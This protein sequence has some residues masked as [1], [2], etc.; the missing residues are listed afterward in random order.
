VFIYKPVTCRLAH[1][2]VTQFGSGTTFY[3]GVETTSSRDLFR[4]RFTRIFYLFVRFYGADYF[5]HLFHIYIDIEKD[6]EAANGQSNL[7]MSLIWLVQQVKE[8]HS[9]RARRFASDGRS[10]YGSGREPVHNK[11][12]L[13]FSS[14]HSGVPLYI[15]SRE[16]IQ[17][18]KRSDVISFCPFE[19][20]WLI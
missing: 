17:L 10:I 8:P 5:V 20:I 6:I 2:H 19:T 18:V 7:E 13:V 4:N 9:D 15:Y 14:L 1:L 3:G 11:F 12:R 16:K